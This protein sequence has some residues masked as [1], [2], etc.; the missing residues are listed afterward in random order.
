MLWFVAL[1]A[2]VVWLSWTSRRALRVQAL[3]SLLLIW[4]GGGTLAA[5]ALASAGPCY[6]PLPQYQQLMTRLDAVGFQLWARSNQQGIWSAQ[7]AHEWL[8]F[9]GVS[10]MPSM[11]VAIAVW[12]AIVVWRRSRP[13]GVLLAAYAVLIQ[14]GSVVL[15][16]H[17]AIDGY[18]GAAIAWLAWSASSRLIEPER[19]SLRFPERLAE[20]AGAKALQSS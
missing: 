1:L 9:G 7:Q 11:H 16:W 17:Y 2:I 8:A 13:L 4:I 15:G 19:S 12:M 6:S 18:A 3:A 14:V 20:S 5:W 10:A